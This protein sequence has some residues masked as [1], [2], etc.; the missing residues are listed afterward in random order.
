MNSI[1]EH[2]KWC[3]EQHANTNHMYDNYLPYEFHL[4]MVDSVAQRYI[5]LIPDVLSPTGYPL[6][7]ACLNAVWGHDLIEDARKSYNDIKNVLGTSAADIIYAVTNE[8]GKNRE[9]RANDTYYKGIRET[10]GAVFV[11]LCDRI[12]NVQYSKMTSD[13]MF[14]L[15][16]KENPHFIESLGY[17][18]SYLIEMFDEL[19][20]NFQVK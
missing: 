20:L 2:R 9:E 8:K 14:M 3:I 10:P 6:K 16:K 5:H 11:K 7:T 17:S 4:R 1:L 15:Y 18:D 19:N 12:A 13:K